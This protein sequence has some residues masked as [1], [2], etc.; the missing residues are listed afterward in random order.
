MTAASLAPRGC[1]AAL[2][3]CPGGPPGCGAGTQRSP[4]SSSDLSWAAAFCR[5]RRGSPSP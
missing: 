3:T 1:G 2:R 4:G 5:H